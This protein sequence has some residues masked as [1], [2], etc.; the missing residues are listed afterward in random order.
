MLFKE[1]KRILRLVVLSVGIAVDVPMIEIQFKG[2]FDLYRLVV[3]F[4]LRISGHLEKYPLDFQLKSS[5]DNFYS[6]QG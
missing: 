4:I 2:F 1:K 5:L 3:L 6:V